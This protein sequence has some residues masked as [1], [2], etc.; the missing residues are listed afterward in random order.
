MLVWVWVDGELPC[1]GGR[2]VVRCLDVMC[3]CVQGW[4][5]VRA[6]L[7]LPSLA[8]CVGQGC[9]AG[10]CLALK[11]GLC[12]W[13]KVSPHYQGYNFGLKLAQVAASGFKCVKLKGFSCWDTVI[14]ANPKS[15]NCLFIFS[16]V[17]YFGTSCKPDYRIYW[18]TPCSIK[19]TNVK[20][21]LT[22]IG[23]RLWRLPHFY[24][25]GTHMWRPL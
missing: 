22:C 23:V 16:S 11:P 18:V 9:A 12:F 24:L 14:E 17:M 7:L 1:A 20:V 13:K 5:S 19:R 4:A 25:S 21:F 15:D 2:E 6:L 3:S 10:V 8:V